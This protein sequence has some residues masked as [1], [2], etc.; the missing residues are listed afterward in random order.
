MSSSNSSQVSIK[1][2]EEKHEVTVIF[3][4]SQTHTEREKITIMDTKRATGFFLLCVVVI[5]VSVQVAEA[6]PTY[7][8][9]SFRCY[10]NCFANCKRE[11]FNIGYCKSKCAM[12]CVSGLSSGTISHHF[13]EMTQL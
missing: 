6:Q 1:D 4:N 5:S 13:S 7:H 9:A 11:T 10:E 2:H 12:E 3:H 8:D